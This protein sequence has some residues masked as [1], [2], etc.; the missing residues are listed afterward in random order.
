MHEKV[1]MIDGAGRGILWCVLILSAQGLRQ[2]MQLIP[3]KKAADA[4]ESAAF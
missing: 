4:D 3:I 1:S 2:I